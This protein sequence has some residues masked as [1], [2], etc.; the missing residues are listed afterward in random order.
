MNLDSATTPR[1][2]IIAYHDGSNVFLTKCVNGTYTQLLSQ[3]VAYVAGA[4]LKVQKKEQCEIIILDLMLPS[5]DGKNITKIIREMNEEYGNPKIIMVT[6][7]S[8]VE[9]VLDGLTIGADD[10]LKKPFDPR[11]LVLRVKKLQAL[12]V[13]SGNPSN[14]NRKDDVII[15]CSIL[16]NK[17]MHQVSESGVPIELTKKEYDLLHLLIENQGI[18]LTREKILDYVWGSDYFLGDR[19]VD[20]YVSKLRDK[21]SDISKN[22]KTIKGVGYRLDVGRE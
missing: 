19:S 21:F 22:L 12:I 16:F 3:S 1:N 9:D 15:Y 7:K 4:T 8:E 20:V 2:F 10:Y 18:V 14:V 17:V 6:A 5:L 11:E 13:G